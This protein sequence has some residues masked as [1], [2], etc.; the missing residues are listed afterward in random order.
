MCSWIILFITFSHKL[1][2]HLHHVPPVSPCPANFPH[3]SLYVSG[4][5]LFCVDSL[6]GNPQPVFFLPKFAVLSRE[7]QMGDSLDLPPR[8]WG[9]GLALTTISDTSSCVYMPTNGCVPTK[10]HMPISLGIKLYYKHIWGLSFFLDYLK[11]GKIILCILLDISS[12]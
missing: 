10:S 6:P 3:L 1:C 4:S 2:L 9:S 12:I 5:F 11:G 7:G 8:Q